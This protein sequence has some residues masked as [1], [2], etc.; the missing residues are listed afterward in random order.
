MGIYH[1]PPGNNI[2]NTM[3]LDKIIEPLANRITKY[4]NI[5]IQGDLNIHIDD[6]SNTDSHMFN[7]TM[8][9]FSFKQHVTSPTHKC[10]HTLDLIYSEINTEL[11]LN[12]C[13]V[14]GCISDHTLVTTDTTLKKAPWE[15][16]EKQSGIL[17]S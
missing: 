13:I 6:L 14:H 12:N 11:T 9:A 7:D 8:Q 4:N 2:T 5:V 15:T 16:T 3:F 17:L 1:P 10:R